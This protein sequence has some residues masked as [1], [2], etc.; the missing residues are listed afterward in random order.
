M[1]NIDQSIS[2]VWPGVSCVVINRIV[3]LEQSADATALVITFADAG[4]AKKISR[5]RGIPQ[6]ASFFARPRVRSSNWITMILFARVFDN[7][8][9]TLWAEIFNR[10]AVGPTG[11][12]RSC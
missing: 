1:A 3:K 6:A 11:S 12:E 10:F 8:R 2:Y 7:G 4:I 5:P 9:F